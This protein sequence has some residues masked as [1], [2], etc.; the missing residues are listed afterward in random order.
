MWLGTTAEPNGIIVL[1]DVIKFPTTLQH[2]ISAQQCDLVNELLSNVVS[3][4]IRVE[5]K[6]EVH[7]RKG[8]DIR[9]FCCS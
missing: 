5:T 6:L 2:A 4:C 9:R 3:V 7:C 8:T 1:N